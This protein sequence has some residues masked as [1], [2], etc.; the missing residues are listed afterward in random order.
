MD[1]ASNETTAPEVLT[2]LNKSPFA[3]WRGTSS[4]GLE[5][6]HLSTQYFVQRLANYLHVEI[7]LQPVPPM[8]LHAGELHYGGGF[9][10]C[11]TLGRRQQDYYLDLFWMGHHAVF[12]AVEEAEFRAIYTST[13]TD[14]DHREA[15]PLVDIVMALNIQLAHSLLH[16]LD[17]GSD[18]NAEDASVPGNQLFRR[19]ISVLETTADSP[20]I[21]DAQA[22]FFSAVYLATAGYFN[23]AYTRCRTAEHIASTLSPSSE[24]QW[25][26][27][28]G[29][30]PL[31]G[32]RMCI[33]VLDAQLSVA[34]GR[35]TS[36]YQMHCIRP[37]EPAQ[38]TSTTFF[39]LMLGL[40]ETVR[41]VFTS[42]TEESSRMFGAQ[43]QG[44][45]FHDDPPMRDACAAILRRNMA[46]LRRWAEQVPPELIVPRLS[47]EPGF[48]IRR[49]T[50]RFTDDDPQW[51]Q[52]QRL[53]LE[54]QYH[55]F[56]ICLYRQFITFSP[57]PIIGTLNSDNNCISCVNHAIVL[58]DI[59]SQALKST[60]A[61]TGWY[62]IQDWLE[63]ATFAAAA[64]ASG[65]PVCPPTPNARKALRSAGELFES[66]SSRSGRATRMYRLVV[67]FDTKIVDITRTFQV[68]YD[69]TTLTQIE[70]MSKRRLNA[71]GGQ[72]DSASSVSETQS[73]TGRNMATTTNTS[74][75]AAFSSLMENPAWP[76]DTVLT[77]ALEAQ[78]PG[79]SPENQLLWDSWLRPAG[80]A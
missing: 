24:T 3:Q 15:H 1:S 17:L 58:T 55:S 33:R 27:D 70:G 16:E 42:Y 41:D 38:F 5:Y 48:S 67:E 7:D 80:F 46:K 54:C 22:Q 37:S 69:L 47:G 12:P 43:E 50:L 60:E 13:W 56:C 71:A 30:D 77:E 65:Y 23:A 76:S 51:Q 31:T 75:D 66:M 63:V 11:D 19:C 68:G 74:G 28:R 52:R 61:L 29:F 79:N 53:I 64:F 6:G 21:T 49:S 73:S 45:H 14:G 44:F 9:G 32:L 34:L 62:Q 78:F 8:S 35:V 57:T 20:T 10:Q 18:I 39:N 25:K 72:R 36:S 26:S 40:S 4:K 2:N 59:L